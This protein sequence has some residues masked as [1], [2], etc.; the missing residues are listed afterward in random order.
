MKRVLR[1]NQFK[2]GTLISHLE[3]ILLLVI[4]FS[5]FNPTFSDS[6]DCAVSL[7]KLSLQRER[8]KSSDSAESRLDSAKL[9]RL[10][11]LQTTGLNR[12]L[13]LEEQAELRSLKE[14]YKNLAIEQ[15]NQHLK[16]RIEKVLSKPKKIRSVVD[17]INL[18][19]EFKGYEFYSTPLDEMTAMDS[20]TKLEAPEG[21]WKTFEEFKS[22][23]A[24]L[25][26]EATDNLEE[27]EEAWRVYQKVTQD[28]STIPFLGR[29]ESFEAIK[30]QPLP[31]GA[32]SYLGQRYQFL[33]SDRWTPVINDFYILGIIH[34]KK[35]AKFMESQSND[36]RKLVRDNITD[37]NTTV[38]ELR[39]LQL[40]GWK[41]NPFGFVS[42]QP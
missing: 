21:G 30:L 8:Q 13:E 37:R 35:L 36:P 3:K 6:A 22:K 38:F 23:T 19:R 4:F 42:P 27:R 31:Q 17:R 40:R 7:A 28:Q 14:E 11:E 29:R 18:V 24:H 12:P 20:I 5:S 2:V 9:K 39:Q 33:W 15:M 10:I 26:S 25:F 32:P 16:N 34:S 1:K 41:A